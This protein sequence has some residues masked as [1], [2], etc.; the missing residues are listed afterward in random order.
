MG[1]TRQLLK[2]CDKTFEDAMDEQDERKS[3]HKACVSGF[4]EGLVDGAIVM[5]PIVLGA[6]WVYKNKAT[7]K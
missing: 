6:C 2:W 4:V 3:M 1:I 7:K 5:Y